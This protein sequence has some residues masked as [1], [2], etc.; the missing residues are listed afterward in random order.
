MGWGKN[1]VGAKNSNV[2][3]KQSAE[4]AGL[5]VEEGGKKV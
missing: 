3:V 4:A 1:N 5:D 2:G